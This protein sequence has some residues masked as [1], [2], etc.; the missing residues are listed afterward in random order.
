MG[1]FLCSHGLMHPQRSC[2]WLAEPCTWLPWLDTAVQ[3]WFWLAP[4]S[5]VRSL[6]NVS[7]SEPALPLQASPEGPPKH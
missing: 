4:V 1:S 5:L 6:C 3:A 2:P 7:T